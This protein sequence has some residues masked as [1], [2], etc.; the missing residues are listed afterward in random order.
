MTYSFYANYSTINRVINP[1]IQQLHHNFTHLWALIQSLCDSLWDTIKSHSFPVPAPF[2]P[3]P[4]GSC[5]D[6]LQNRHVTLCTSDPLFQI[7]ICDLMTLPGLC[8]AC[9]TEKPK[10]LLLHKSNLLLDLDFIRYIFVPDSLTPLT[11]KVF[12]EFLS[13]IPKLLG[14]VA[15]NQTPNSKMKP[16]KNEPQRQPA[17][18]EQST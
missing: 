9:R 5:Y 6:D 3:S 1:S 10:I 8:A 2:A 12:L 17:H 13:K 4:R 15:S 7:L 11:I 18:L 14:I 16:F